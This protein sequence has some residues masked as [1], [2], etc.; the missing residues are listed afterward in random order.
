[1]PFLSAGDKTDSNIPSW[2]GNEELNITNGTH[3]ASTSQQQQQ[4]QPPQQNGQQN[5]GSPSLTP[6]ST[7]RTPKE[8]SPTHLLYGHG[9]CKW[10]GCETFCDDYQDFLK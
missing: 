7:N 9:V 8:D 4:P 2:K 3:P 1:M 6:P 5:V 10:P